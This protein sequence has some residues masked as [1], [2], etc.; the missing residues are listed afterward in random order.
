MN[1]KSPNRNGDHYAIARRRMVERFKKKGIRDERVLEVM[2]VIPRHLFVEEA[3]QPRA[4][5]DHPLP[6]G[7]G[8]TISQPY[9]VALMTELLEVKPED[10][11]LE[12]GAGSGYQTAILAMLAAQV[13]AVERIPE[14]ANRAQSRLEGL[15][16]KNVMISSFDGT[17]GWSEYAP[18]DGIL[19]AAASESIPQP[20]VD[21]LAIGGR[22]LI[23]VG[24]ESQQH[25]IRLIKR[26]TENKIE[27][28][29]GCVF[30]K[31]I[32]EHGWEE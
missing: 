31:L 20:Y 4:Y 28:H 13:Y 17:L 11:I 9:M 21:Q 7:C 1:F 26:E 25:L 15:G 30:V 16:L 5:E 2:S 10:R 18:Y 8:Q 6:I 14:L 27:N 19:V 23:P 12:I 32:G 22:L 3:L 24:D 29:G